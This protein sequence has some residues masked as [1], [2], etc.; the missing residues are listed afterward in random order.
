MTEQ[1]F[2]TEMRRVA[3][4]RE[5]ADPLMSEYWVGFTRGLRR[6]YHG[7]KFGTAAEHRQWLALERSDDPARKQRGKGYRDAIEFGKKASRIGRP[8]IG[9]VV[10]DKITVPSELE[11][12]LESKASTLGLT[13]PDTRREAYKQFTAD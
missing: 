9:D 7:P 4:L 10:L 13:M 2:R 11:T 12:A 3:L 6:V 8:K 5:S 1:R